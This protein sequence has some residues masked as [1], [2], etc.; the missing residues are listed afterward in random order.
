MKGR[1]KQHLKGDN[2]RHSDAHTT[3][4]ICNTT[5]QMPRKMVRRAFHKECFCRDQP[6]GGK[7][8]IFGSEL[9]GAPYRLS[10]NMRQQ[11]QKLKPHEG[12]YHFRRRFLTNA[13]PV[14]FE[15][16][17]LLS[18]MWEHKRHITSYSQFRMECRPSNRVLKFTNSS[19]K[20]QFEDISKVWD[21]L[22]FVRVECDDEK[23]DR[24]TRCESSSS[25]VWKAPWQ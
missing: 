4:M 3:S 2:T 17:N 25:V 12:P 11:H 6:R 8:D 20:Y 21:E 14:V 16:T 18:P 23:V 13:I 10:H 1:S 5:K 7:S 9:K 19:A 15:D 24:W 22:Y